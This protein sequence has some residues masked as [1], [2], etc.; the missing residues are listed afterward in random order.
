MSESPILRYSPDFAHS[1]TGA[2][3]S[4]LS[5]IYFSA[6]ND[7][8]S[9]T[10]KNP[11][12]FN[13]AGLYSLTSLVEN[14]DKARMANYLASHIQASD[15]SQ[16]N[17]MYFLMESL[18]QLLEDDHLDIYSSYYE[19]T[20]EDGIDGSAETQTDIISE[21]ENKIRNLEIPEGSETETIEADPEL[22]GSRADQANI[23]LEGEKINEVSSNESGM[24]A[25][26]KPIDGNPEKREEAKAG[27][28]AKPSKEKMTTFRE[29]REKILER[30]MARF[31]K[32]A[33]EGFTQND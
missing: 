25:E 13:D 33:S 26:L 17:V 5:D 22:M 15:A 29:L 23:V 7:A 24:I 30:Y 4:R 28:K 16:R 18:N 20:F 14:W 3:K 1:L 12:S 11:D 27:E 8:I 32:L 21:I 9:E 6:L 10:H 2:Q 19:N 31:N